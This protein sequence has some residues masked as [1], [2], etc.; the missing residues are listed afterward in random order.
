MLLKRLPRTIIF[1]VIFLLIGLLLQTQIL[2]FI[3]TVRSAP[4]SNKTLEL[5]VTQPANPLEFGEEGLLT[6]S[7]TNTDEE[8]ATNV[9]VKLPNNRSLYY[10]GSI[11]EPDDVVT[12]ATA[13]FGDIAP[14]ETVVVDVPI[15]IRGV[16]SQGVAKLNLKAKGDGGVQSKKEKFDIDIVPSWQPI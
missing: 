3:A 12:R 15:Q 14:D 2:N 4:S 6:L 11:A 7:V 10:T 16:P 9:T 13:E 1:V 5:D 8:T